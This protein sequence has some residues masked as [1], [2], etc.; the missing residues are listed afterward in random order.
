MLTT[1][2]LAYLGLAALLACS[3]AMAAGAEEELTLGE[4]GDVTEYSFT[5]QSMT[6]EDAV[7]SASAVVA[8]EDDTVV[9][10]FDSIPSD[11]YTVIVTY[12]NASAGNSSTCARIEWANELEEEDAE[13][14]VTADYNIADEA[15]AMTVTESYEYFGHIDDMDQTL[16]FQCD[17][18]NGTEDR[19]A[20]EWTPY[21]TNAGHDWS[22]S[23]VMGMGEDQGHTIGVFDENGVSYGTK[24]IN[25]KTTDLTEDSAMEMWFYLDQETGDLKIATYEY[26]DGMDINNCYKAVA[27]EE[28]GKEADCIFL[29]ETDHGAGNFAG[30]FDD[31]APGQYTIDVSCYSPKDD[32]YFPYE[33]NEAWEQTEQVPVQVIWGVDGCYL[34]TAEGTGAN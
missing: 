27:Y 7:Y 25:F 20:L 22:C 8:E 23:I 28:N 34:Q 14:S 30:T 21:T 11:T 6:D 17:V 15:I 33:W 31:L 18:I 1:R 24:E 2:K 3:P 16:Y 32:D 5:L 29:S 9:A 4:P 13:C 10:Y 26:P 12:L 19:F